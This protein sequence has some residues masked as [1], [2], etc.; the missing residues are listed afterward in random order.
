MSDNLCLTVMKL[1][2]YQNC[3][4]PQLIQYI[5]TYII[6]FCQSVLLEHEQND[7]KGNVL[8]VIDNSHLY[9]K[10]ILRLS[11]LLLYFIKSFY[12][13]VVGIHFEWIANVAQ[14]YIKLVKN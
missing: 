12:V 10:A 2:A 6:K 9:Q 5:L 8:Q 13:E 4:N 3:R 1:I 7:I 14:N 11:T